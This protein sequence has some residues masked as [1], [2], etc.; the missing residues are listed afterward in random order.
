MLNIAKHCELLLDL[1]DF[2][3]A[4]LEFKLNIQ[5]AIKLNRGLEVGSS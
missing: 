3:E 4:A 5:Q 1:W 2:P